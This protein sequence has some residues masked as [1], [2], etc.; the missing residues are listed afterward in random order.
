MGHYP[1]IFDVVGAGTGTSEGGL[2]FSGQNYVIVRSV[3]TGDPGADGF[4]AGGWG[5]GD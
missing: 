3:N 2:T 5:H 1:K 4:R